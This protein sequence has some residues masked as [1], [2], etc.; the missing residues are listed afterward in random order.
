MSTKIQAGLG[1]EDIG[2]LSGLLNTED[3]KSGTPLELTLDVIDEDPN[4]P[5]KENNPGFSKENL[6]ELAETIRLRGVKTPISVRENQDVPGR[7]IINHGARRFRASLIAKKATIPAFIDHDYTEVDQVIE[8][9]QRNELTSREIA[10][11]IGRELAKGSK[12]GEI[13]SSIGKS[14]A[15]V[16]QHVTLLNLPEPIANAYNSGRVN[17]VTIVNE[18]V[19][20]CKKHPNE[21]VAWLS[22]GQE[23]TRGSVKMLREYLDVKRKHEDESEPSIEQVDAEEAAPAKKAPVPKEQDP[24]KLK[25]AIVMIKHDDRMGRLMLNRRPS[26]DGWAWIKYEDD[27]HEVEVELGMVELMSLMDGA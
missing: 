10:N 5:R 19:K 22:D 24:D 13:A 6:Y 8:N 11:F 4:Q 15:F 7:F 16:S 20:A 12:K 9:L 14:A 21:V 26:T 1:L 27:G 17:D 18:L 2:D 25:K 23:V 3:T